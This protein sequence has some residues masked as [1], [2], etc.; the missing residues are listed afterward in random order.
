LPPTNGFVSE[1]LT[2]QSLF[3]GFAIPDLL[4]KIL[5]PI[6]AAMLALTGALAVACFAK[7]FGISFLAMPRSAH[8]KRATEVPVSMRLGMGWLAICCIALGAAPMAVVPAIDRI[9]TGLTDATIVDAM[10]TTGGLALSPGTSSGFGSVSTPVLWLLLGGIVLLALV[11]MRALR[12]NLTS[13]RYRTWGCGIALKPR[14]EYTAT[15]FTQ[16]IRQ[17]FSTIYRPTVKIETDLIETSR[18][19]A[20][21]MRFEVHIE[22]TFQ[23]YLYDPVVRAFNAVAHRLRV[24]Q[25]GSLHLYLSYI[26]LMLLALLLWVV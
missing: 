20:R 6:T 15:G 17:V 12:A 2:F 9:T 24:L 4:I 23:K 26:F 21:R 25:P 13:R 14:M 19:F 16:P 11:G 8:A 5:M 10:V 22:S 18:Y 1:W 7:A 3:A